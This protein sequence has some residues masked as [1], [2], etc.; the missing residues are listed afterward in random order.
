VTITELRHFVKLFLISD[1]WHLNPDNH[2]SYMG[3]ASFQDG[4]GFGPQTPAAAGNSE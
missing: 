3:G 1:Y 2:P 4:Q